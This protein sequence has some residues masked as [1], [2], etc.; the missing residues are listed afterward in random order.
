MSDFWRYR[1]LLL[2]FFLLAPLAG[3]YGNFGDPRGF[4]A[5][6]Q[7]TET[8]LHPGV[9]LFRADGTWNGLKQVTHVVTVDLTEPTVALKT[10]PGERFVNA[11]TG[12]FFR[13]SLVS[14]LQA[15]NN[16]LVA[17]NTAFFD[18]SNPGTQTPTGLLMSE[19][20]M[21]R[22]PLSNRQLLA[23]PQ[24][25]LP[26]MTNFT[27]SANVSYNGTSRSVIGMNRNSISGG[28]IVAY[29]Q[30]WDRSPGTSAGFTSGQEITE[31]VIRKT[32]F[33]QSTSRTTPSR[34]VG[35][36]LSVR[37]NLGSIAIGADQMVLTASGSARAFLQQM[38]VGSTVELQWQLSGGPASLDW[39]TLGE[40]VAGSAR[41]IVD[42]QRQSLSTDHWNARHPRSAVGL[43][44]DGKKLLLLLIEGRQTGRA[45]GMSLHDTAR[46]LEHLG[47]R[48]AL[49]FDGGGSSALAARVN[50][51]NGLV[52]TPSDGSERYV[53]AGLGIVVVPEEPNPFFKNI[54]ITPGANSALIS[55]ETP[56]PATS[57]A[58]YGTTG[59]DRH[60]VAETVATT[61]HTVLLHDLPTTGTA[62]VRLVAQGPRGE[63]VSH[64]IEVQLGTV[65]MDDPEATFTG[66]WD[67]GS[68]PTPWGPSYRSAPTV[69]GT[70]NRTATFRPDL[71]IT[72][73]YDVYVWF[74]HGT[75]RPVAAQYRIK[76]TNGITS[77]T[78]NQTT[79][80]SRWRLLTS[81]LHFTA[82]GDNYLQVLN[83]DGVGGKYVMADGVQLVLKQPTPLPAGQAPSWWLTHFF[84][85]NPPPSHIDADGDGRSLWEEF[86]WATDPTDPESRPRVRLNPLEHGGWQLIFSPF[87]AD[88][89]YHVQARSSLADD[90]VTLNALPPPTA[91]AE[92][93]GVF[94]IP[95][96]A[97][98]QFFQIEVRQQ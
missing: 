95:A 66:A 71:G 83:S 30:P 80:G 73:T 45:E 52:S 90:W 96:S 77:H 55:W 76:H 92:G 40:V 38:T 46:Y 28:Q 44:P 68:W 58:I 65:I 81:N 84:G 34:I 93:K 29:Q 74:V 1:L 31:V 35:Q 82:G 12:Q 47:V 98:F 17:I 49:E 42:G 87:R 15:D 75:N 36:V 25:G 43:S 13:R 61:R 32:S 69:S 70:A 4:L 94:E 91:N 16:A 62:Y 20:V 6:Q 9:N 3:A 22:E 60:T 97:P 51:L 59:Y 7:V 23:I 85:N 33:N 86:L 37:N 72:G 78:I 19:G 50:G 54:R 41:L 2:A 27:L 89:S 10:L 63:F 57:H 53:P 67:T 11:G 14:Q 24:N 79:N 5:N 26:V 88:R 39:N 8:F 21:L 64:S 18:I 48:N 56:S